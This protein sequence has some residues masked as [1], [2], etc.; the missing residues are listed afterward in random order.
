MEKFQRRFSKHRTT[1]KSNRR[2][3]KLRKEQKQKNRRHHKL[4][5]TNSIRFRKTHIQKT[6]HR[7]LPRRLS[8]SQKHGRSLKRIL[9]QIPRRHQ[10]QKRNLDGPS[11]TNLQRQSRISCIKRKNILNRTKKSKTTTKRNNQHQIKIQHQRKRTT[12]SKNHLPNR[13]RK[14][15]NLRT[16]CRNLQ[17]QS[18]NHPHSSTT[19]RFLLRSYRIH[20]LHCKTNRTKKHLKRKN[21]ILH[22]QNPNQNVQRKQR[23]L[24]NIQTRQR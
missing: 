13:K 17:R 16:L 4:T 24:R 1:K 11:R 20:G 5:Q 21:Q 14:T 19:N 7:K 6:Q 9:L 12:S 3:N 23:Q 22:Q 10:H 2:R 15:I 18:R 8:N